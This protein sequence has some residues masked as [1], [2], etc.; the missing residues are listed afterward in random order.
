[1]SLSILYWNCAAGLY[2][3]LPFLQDFVTHKVVDI[4]YVAETDLK[5]T[6]RTDLYNIQGYRI[7]LS[8]T[9]N[10]KGKCRLICYAKNSSNLKLLAHL[11]KDDNEIIV[12]GSKNS[13]TVGIYFP[14]KLEQGETRLTNLNTL[15][16]NLRDIA[17]NLNSNY[18]IN[19][20]GDFNVNTQKDSRELDILRTWSDSFGLAQIVEEE[21]R[22]R[23]SLQQ[24]GY[25]L[26][27]SIIDH[28]YTSD[29]SNISLD[30]IESNLSDHK[31]IY[32]CRNC[33]KY[34]TKKQKI[35]IVD[36]RNYSPHEFASSVEKNLVGLNFE[37]SCPNRLYSIVCDVLISAMNKNCPKR[38][39]IIRNPQ[40][41][42]SS[43]ITAIT[44]KRDRLLKKIKKL[45]S[46]GKPY[47]VLTSQAKSLSK[48]I[49]KIIAKETKR[50]VRRKIEGCSSRSFW[51][52]VTGLLGNSG[53]NTCHIRNEYGPLSDDAAAEAFA[54][55]FK[56][57]VTNLMSLPAVSPA[58][59]EISGPFCPF[60]SEEI[61]TALSQARPKRSTGPDEIPMSV[62]KDAQVM[63][64]L[65]KKLYDGVLYTGCVP[66]GWKKALVRPVFK[67]GEPSDIKNY[68][69]ISNLSTISKLFERVLLNRINSLYPGVDGQNQH[70]FWANHSTV[71][72]AQEI[73]HFISSYLDKGLAV[74][75]YSL[76][77]SAA[78]DLVDVN[79]FDQVLGRLKFDPWIRRVLVD[80]LTN[81]SAYVAVGESQ[82]AAFSLEVG[83]AQGS[84][85]GP[86][87]FNIY[88]SELISK[89]L[90]GSKIVSYADDSYVI[91]SAETRDL[92]ISKLSSLMKTHLEWLKSIGMHSNVAKTEAMIMLDETPVSLGC[93]VTSGQES[94]YLYKSINYPSG[95]FC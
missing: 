28:V 27:E 87:I 62:L 91:V 8:K 59:I 60:T 74:G 30:L 29:K 45:K 19:V 61:L 12:M 92:M 50:T 64:P 18:S 49:P 16:N 78:F 43:K 56:E 32:F 15:V 77:L 37:I 81:R 35:I 76:D 42:I 13:V 21:T 53:D 46:N 20:L 10:T 63:I 2:N 4:I 89:E 67:K 7:E 57:K 38:I 65:L 9:F 40:H 52:T 48:Q 23:V 93:R 14:F 95:T 86:K 31:A 69:P 54:K 47:D 70:G 79:V 24:N 84:T 83:C 26:E 39:C 66:Y 55:F 90:E 75:I 58:K 34:D 33:V 80:F 36:W 85:L 6:F 68:R 71:T 44:K 94:V 88:V 11:E 51:K 73:Q 25:R 5:P 1:M 82:S 22:T 17:I 41:I 3:K 72:A